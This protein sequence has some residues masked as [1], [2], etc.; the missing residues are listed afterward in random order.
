MLGELVRLADSKHPTGLQA[1]MECAA[2]GTPDPDGRGA[3]FDQEP[4]VAAHARFH[5]VGFFVQ[6]H[7]GLIG[8]A[9]QTLVALRI[10]DTRQP[11]SQLVGERGG[12][13]V[14]LLPG[15]VGNPHGVRSIGQMVE[16]DL[17]NIRLAANGEIQL[18][19]STIDIYYYGYGF[20][21]GVE[22]YYYWYPAEYVIVT[23]TWI[24]YTSI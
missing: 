11:A 10:S 19:Q 13:H 3:P 20:D 24:E 15:N 21:T 17:G 23:E 2:Q 7:A 8:H 12:S 9:G 1:E 14:R 6:H 18:A 22:E 4:G 16:L 5:E